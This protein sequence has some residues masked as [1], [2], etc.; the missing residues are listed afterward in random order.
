[1]TWCGYPAGAADGH[2]WH[3]YQVLLRHRDEVAAALAEQGIG[4]SVHFIPVH[5]L[6][7]FG[8]RRSGTWECAACP[9]TDLVG[10]TV[11]VA[12]A[13]SRG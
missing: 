13:V 6:S 8:T 12:A 9:V 3:L 7:A 2:A 1:M 11:A 5:Q 4:T 10:R